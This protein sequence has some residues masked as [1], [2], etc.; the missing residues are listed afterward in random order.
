MAGPLPGMERT[1]GVRLSEL[2][3]YPSFPMSAGRV[4]TDHL[5]TA[6]NTPLRRRARHGRMD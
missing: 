2:M 6:T 1:A 5:Y 4:L 3:Y